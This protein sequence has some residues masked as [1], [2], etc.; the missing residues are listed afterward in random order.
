MGDLNAFIA[1]VNSQ[2]GV[3]YVFGGDTPAGFDCSGLMEWAAAQ[4]GF[5]I[6]RTSE[7]Q[8]AALPLVNNPGPGDLIFFN[9]FDG[10]APPSHVGMC[11]NVGCTIMVD[12]AHTGTNVRT[13]STAGFGTIMGYGRLAS[14]G[15]VTPPAG[16]GGFAQGWAVGDAP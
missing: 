8:F 14:S 7:E 13:E 16:G 1:A 2:I 15:P 12:A 4:A 6:P 10:Q 11:T 3:P 9:T 5:S